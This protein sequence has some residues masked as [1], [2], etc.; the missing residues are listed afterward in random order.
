MLNFKYIP[1]LAI[2]II[3]S[4]QPVNVQENNPCPLMRDYQMS[5][6]DFNLDVYDIPNING[7][8]IA[9]I[10]AGRR[11]SL[12]DIYP[13]Y[14][15]GF[16]WYE[17]VTFSVDERGWISL[18]PR[19]SQVNN[20]PYYP[21]EPISPTIAPTPTP[22]VNSSRAETTTEI[23][24]QKNQDLI[25][26]I[27]WFIAGAIGL[28]IIIGKLAVDL[29]NNLST[30]PS[31]NKSLKQ[32]GSQTLKK[33]KGSR[34]NGRAKRK[35]IN[36]TQTDIDLPDEA[37]EN[38]PNSIIEADV[39]S[40]FLANDFT[41]IKNNVNTDQ[42]NIEDLSQPLGLSLE[43]CITNFNQGNKAFFDDPSQF[44]YLKPTASVIHGKAGNLGLGDR[45]EFEEGEK[46]QASYLA[47]TIG[48]EIWLIPNLLLSRWQ[49]LLANNS[50]FDSYS[51][52]QNPKLVKPAKLILVGDRR[53]RMVEKGVFN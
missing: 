33:L 4:I 15:D 8:I 24:A 21:D 23:G 26:A 41:Q 46:R 12:S 35:V 2:P 27:Y 50:F 53:W 44:Q 17:I 30:K 9:E 14:Y 13:K 20:L 32:I 31:K 19:E 25:I 49:R 10:P 29:L 51:N 47:F 11:F 48:E 1:I 6:S 52:L 34:V 22:T 38:T 3:W 40:H 45:Q 28:S 5:F 18:Q 39:Y 37:E 42:E 16:C 36:V 43:Y 7:E